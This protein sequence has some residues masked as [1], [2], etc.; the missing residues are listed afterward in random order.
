MKIEDIYKLYTKSYL[1]DTDTRKIRKGSIFFA[2]KGDNFD[3]NKF[4]KTALEEGSSY[5]IVDNKAYVL[6]SKTILV[7][8]TL[9]TLQ[10]LAHYHRNKLGIPVIALT[11]SNGKTTTKELIYSVLKKRFNV[12]ATSGNLNNHIGVPLTLLTMTPKTELGLVEMGANHL[13][14]IEFLCKIAQPNYGYITNFGKAHLEGFGGVEGVIKGKSELYNFLKLSNGFAFINT[15]DPLQIEQAKGLKTIPFNSSKIELLE[16]SQFVSVL[17]NNERIFSNLIG[18]YNFSNIAAAIAIGAYFKISTLEIKQAIE[19]YI[20]QN[21]RSQI[22][23]KN[24]VQIIMD[25]YNANPSSMQA[26]LSNFNNIKS[27]VKIVILGDMFELGESS[28]AEHQN[29]ADLALSLNLSK[30][31][32]IGKAF[33][34]I[35]AKNALVYNNFESFKAAFNPKNLKKATILIKG[36]RGM[37]LERILDFF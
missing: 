33:S 3:G 15:D 19:S 14:E 20:P 32:L 35:D 16:S 22:I 34:A 30:V 13:K 31:Y 18:A 28:T 29:I 36:S 12:V 25:A 7:S 21:H 9:E 27:P 37:A 11:G 17:F 26:A 6:N 10:E 4:A 8:N 24:G 2:L 5:A 1:V 23:E